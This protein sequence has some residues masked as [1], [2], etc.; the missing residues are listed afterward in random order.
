MERC[1]DCG[2]EWESIPASEVGER[3]RQ[4]ALRIAELLQAD[5]VVQRSEPNRWSS[6]E[7]AAHVRDVLLSLRDRIVVALVE[8]D[9]DFK[10]MYRDQRV[11]FGLYATDT[12]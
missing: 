5:G 2:F 1:E 8:D 12:P 7:Y 4:G 11:G 9:P 10:P 3:T 6:L